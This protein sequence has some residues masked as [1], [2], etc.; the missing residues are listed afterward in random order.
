M[1]RVIFGCLVAC[2]VLLT[3][4][5]KKYKRNGDWA[6]G[7]EF[8]GVARLAPVTF[9]LGGAT[10]I[11]LGVDVDRNELVDF[12]KTTD[13]KT[14]IEVED[15]PGEA[16][17]GAVAFVVDG[18]AYVGLGYRDNE[19]KK[20]ADWDPTLGKNPEKWF[21]D[22][23]S[24]DGEKWSQAEEIADFPEKAEGR[25]YGL[26]FALNGK[27][28]AGAGYTES[29]KTVSTYYSYD[30]TTNAW[31]SVGSLGDS[32]QGGSVF[33]IDN[34]AY[35]CLGISGTSS[36]EYQ[37][38]FFRY[39]G[40]KVEQLHS[41][42]NVS[43]GKFDNDYAQI[44]RVYASSFVAN[45]GGEPYAYIVSGR[46]GATGQVSKQVFEYNPRTDRWWTAED[47]LYNASGRVLGS[48]FSIGDKGYIT[49]GGTTTIV[50]GTTRVWI[51][52]PGVKEWDDNDYGIVD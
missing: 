8:G 27:G 14:W 1:K 37:T 47:L 2:V 26:G 15:F 46:A 48:G 11:G 35:I 13:G 30:P 19:G 31:T 44:P 33:V 5:D 21:R 17:Y 38:D 42:V 40:T 51:Y 7:S 4:C 24:F 52:T 34:W 3:S 36:S 12:W 23:Y 10:Y 22:F 50:P 20:P 6:R 16:R 43:N 39:D 18:K 41:L 45:R 49:L 32:R 9:Q 28:Y 25:Y 29:K